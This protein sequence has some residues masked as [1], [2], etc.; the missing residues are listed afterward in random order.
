MEMAEK[1]K[2][3]VADVIAEYGRRLFGYIRGKVNTEA[4][5][6]DLL[7]DVWYQFSSLSDMNEIQSMSG[8]LYQVAKNKVKDFYRKKKPEALEDFS[9]END[10]GEIS[11]RDLLL[12]TD[13]DPELKMFKEIFWE[14]LMAGL[15]ELPPN[16][17]EVFILNELEDMTLQ[18]IAD[19]N[20]ENIKTVIS[21]KG[22]AV[23]HLRTRLTHLYNELNT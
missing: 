5:A 9:Y 1:V 17:K 18:E 10:E 23:K 11:F 8:W 14:E 15:D 7:Q 2:Y 16:Q 20:N 12:A 13:A 4:D 19:K 6:E 22:Y 21:R 3:N